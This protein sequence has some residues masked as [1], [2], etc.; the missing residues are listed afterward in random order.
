MEI[1][2][3]EFRLPEIRQIP[4]PSTQFVYMCYMYLCYWDK[5]KGEI[6]LLKRG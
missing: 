3:F 2:S 4:S 5:D 1:V 6:K